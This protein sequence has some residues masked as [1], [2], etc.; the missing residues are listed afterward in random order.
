MSETTKEYIYAQD[1]KISDLDN[2]S[3]EY[4]AKEWVKFFFYMPE[5]HHPQS[6]YV[7]PYDRRREIDSIQESFHQSE[8]EKTVGIWH[9]LGGYVT[10]FYTTKLP[11]YR[12]WA[13]MFSPYA[14]FSSTEEFPSIKTDQE[15]E[16]FVEEDVNGL[17]R[18]EVKINR[19][20][21]FSEKKP[22][23]R[24]RSSVEVD[25]RQDNVF[26]ISPTRNVK[27]FFDGYFVLLR[28]LSPG[29]YIIDSTGKAPNYEKEVRYAIYTRS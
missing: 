12:K 2:K 5:E 6:H 1:E 22:P 13:I 19:K 16:K 4:A 26:G 8:D 25:I 17:D 29:D 10:G 15:L 9:L 27:V 20:Q 24:I 18:L 11:V 23:P 21:Y 7:L 28:P 3:Y 14:A